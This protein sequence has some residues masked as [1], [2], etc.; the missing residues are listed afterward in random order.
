[1]AWPQTHCSLNFY[2]FYYFLNLNFFKKKPININFY[3]IKKINNF[4][5]DALKIKRVQKT[6]KKLNFF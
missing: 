4:K 3:S 5:N 2:F 1:V 6:F